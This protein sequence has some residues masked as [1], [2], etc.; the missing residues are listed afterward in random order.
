MACF[1]SYL[2]SMRHIETGTICGTTFE[3][4]HY[5]VAHIQ[6]NLFSVCRMPYC[7]FDITFFFVFLLILQKSNIW[8]AQLEIRKKIFRKDEKKFEYRLFLSFDFLYLG[9]FGRKSPV[10]FFLEMKKF[11]TRE[12]EILFEHLIQTKF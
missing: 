10:S 5:F 9:Y 4:L 1:D 3:S 8:A 11:Q 12:T 2:M 7:D 6:L